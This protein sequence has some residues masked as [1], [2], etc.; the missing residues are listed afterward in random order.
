MKIMTNTQTRAIAVPDAL[1][2]KMDAEAAA[3][4]KN[5]ERELTNEEWESQLPKP[6]GY[7]L[8]VALPDVEKYYQGSTLLKTTDQCQR[9]HHVDHGHRNRYGRWAYTDKNVF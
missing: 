8:L 6:T 7:R 5:K 9:V 2:K 3:K 4:P 1:R